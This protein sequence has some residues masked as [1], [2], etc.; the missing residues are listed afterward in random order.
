MAITTGTNDGIKFE[1]MLGGGPPHMVTMEEKYDSTKGWLVGCILDIDTSGRLFRHSGVGANA[2]TGAFAVAMA[3][4]ACTADGSAETVAIM[5][6]PN[7]VF[8]A[9]VAHLTTGSAVTQPTQVGNTYQLCCSATL[10]TSLNYCIELATTASAGAHIIG[11][12]D[13]S[14]TAYG[15]LYFVFNGTYRAQSP[16]GMYTSG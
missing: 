7:T 12:K 3:P 8:S 15:R 13:A 16:F 10:G 2:T 1:Y 14:G 5:I 6:T 4:M 11:M 9:K